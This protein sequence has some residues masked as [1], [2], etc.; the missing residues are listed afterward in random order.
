MT[1][2]LTADELAELRRIPSPTVANA[3]ER[4]GVRDRR[5]GVTGPGVLCLFPELGP[6]VGY[7]ATLTVRSAHP[8]SGQRVS[9]TGWPSMSM[10]TRL[11]AVISR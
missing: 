3:V 6:L 1:P 9:R 5:E 11:E 4:L 10:S 2:P 8:P 7:A